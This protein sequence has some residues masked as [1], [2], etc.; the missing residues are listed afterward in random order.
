MD[1]PYGLLYLGLDLDLN[2]EAQKE[3]KVYG[4]D[5][6]YMLKVAQQF[7][8]IMFPIFILKVVNGFLLW[9]FLYLLSISQT[10]SVKIII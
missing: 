4:T 10:F 2:M 6:L 1:S 5:K 3:T 8:H 9:I 7:E